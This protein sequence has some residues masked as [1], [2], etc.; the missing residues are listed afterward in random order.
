MGPAKGV[1][2]DFGR[3]DVRTLT[4][5]AEIKP[6][7]TSD[8]A[9]I[10]KREI[11]G[12]TVWE[13]TEEN[14]L[15]LL[16]R[17]LEIQTKLSKIDVKERLTLIDSLG[18]IWEERL[19]NGVFEELAKTLSKNTGYSRRLI[20]AE[21]SLVPQVLN[22]SNIRK[23]LEASF[24]LG[25]S[26]L[27]RFVE[28]A[29]GEYFRY[30]PVG[31]VLII[32]SGNSLIPPLIPTTLSLITGNFTLLRPSA[33]NYCA[34]VEVYKPIRDL[35]ELSDTA[36]LFSEALVICYF[37]HESPTFKKLLTSGSLGLV[38]FWGGEPARTIVGKLV[39]ENP[40]HPRYLVNGPLTGFAIVDE[41]SAD[42]ICAKGLAL[43]VI[44]YDQQLCSSPTMAVFIGSWNIAM[45]FTERVGKFLDDIGS[46]YRF[47]SKDDYYYMLQSVRRV[48]QMKGSKVYCSNKPDNMWTL[49]LS[50]GESHLED[51]LAY[52]PAFNI[53]NRKRF[54]EIVVVDSVEKAI[55]QVV[56]L[57]SNVAFT[58]VDGVQTVGLAVEEAERERLL[59]GLA[60]V[61]VYRITPIEDMYMRSPVEPYDGVFL[62]STLTYTTYSRKKTIL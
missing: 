41:K 21:L 31:P 28:L 62:A 19:E 1:W 36:R 49:I 60:D 29:E 22:A 3:D 32:S 14:A 25:L 43:N 12:N 54:L 35:A 59:E 33:T 44:L 18:K 48:L 38:N 27:E 39:S 50:R 17:G 40:N 51:A 46:G 52:F 58:G 9:N 8:T 23:N 56:N 47:E 5:Y 30:M 6:F 13:L 57:S 42:D 7:V 2:W 26:A 11:E 61:G 55:Q 53:Y 34:V 45:E 10:V 37:T 16:R 24:K 15:G 20:D 4:N